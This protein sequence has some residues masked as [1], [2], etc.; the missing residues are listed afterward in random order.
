MTRRP[1]LF[2]V[3]ALASLV[4]CGGGGGD[5]GGTPPVQYVLTVTPATNGTIALSPAGGTYAAGTVVT[6][7]A[8]PAGGYQ[9]AAWTGAL[10]GTTNPATVTMDAAKTVGATFSLVPVSECTQAANTAEVARLTA[11]QPVF[12]VRSKT[13]RTFTTTFTS[14]G[15]D[16]TVQCPVTLQFKDLSGDSALQPYEDWT[17]SA[18]VRAAD[19]VGRMSAAEKQALLLHPA[20][21]DNPTT[22]ATTVVSTATQAFISAGVR[23]GLTAANLGQPPLR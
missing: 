12:G 4:A 23:Y 16:P 18:D 20:L 17:K 8:T 11:A 6:V 13:V 14:L 22:T 19:L 15:G 1:V 10:S 5:D 2:L 3:V 9:L 21:P 7:T